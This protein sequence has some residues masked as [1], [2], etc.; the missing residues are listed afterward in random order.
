MTTDPMIAPNPA[1]PDELQLQQA[2][3]AFARGDYKSA[4]RLATPLARASGPAATDAAEQA[5]VEQEARALLVRLSPHRLTKLFFALTLLLLCI[6]TAFA[7]S[8]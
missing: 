2:Q 4:R 6:V 5:S 7:Y 3:A 8:Q 1:T